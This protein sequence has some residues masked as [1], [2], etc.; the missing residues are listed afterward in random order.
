MSRSS[1]PPTELHDALLVEGAVPNVD[2]ELG[3]RTQA[4]FDELANLTG[5]EYGCSEPRLCVARRAVAD[6]GG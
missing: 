2:V 1:A 4:Y 5:G 6:A 3:T